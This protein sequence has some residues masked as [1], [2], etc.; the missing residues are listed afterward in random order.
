VVSKVEKRLARKALKLEQT[1]QKSARQFIEPSLSR[2]VAEGATV[3]AK[4][5]IPE[6][7]LTPHQRLMKWDRTLEDKEAGKWSW[8]DDRKCCDKDWDNRVHPFLK[9]YEKKKWGEIDSETTGPRRKRRK[10]H[11]YYTFDKLIDEAYER[12]VDME[13]NDFAPNIFRFRLSGKRRLYGFRIDPTAM[14]HMIWFDA[15][16]RLYKGPAE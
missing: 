6:P 4:K 1:L 13:L 15:K 11:V 9:E 7:E 10:K 8:G 5:R 3:E 2:S 14:F 12:L 16:H